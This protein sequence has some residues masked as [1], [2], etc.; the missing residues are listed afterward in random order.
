MS[1]LRSQH[2]LSQSRNSPHFTEPGSSL[3]LTQQPDICPA[4][5]TTLPHAK[6]F[7][8]VR[9][10][11]YGC[12]VSS[13]SVR[14]AV[15][16]ICLYQSSRIVPVISVYQSSR[17]V[18]V[19]CLYQS[20]RAVPVSCLYQSSRAVF[21]VLSLSLQQGNIRSTNFPI[22]SI[23]K[24]NSKNPLKPRFFSLRLLH[25]KLPPVQETSLNRVTLM[26]I[27]YFCNYSRGTQKVQTMTSSTPL[28]R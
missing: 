5:Q 24:C 22:Q 1:F 21:S 20:S 13:V 9:I 14:M 18:S 10:S 23:E 26:I 25:N 28:S 2:V 11:Q 6:P 3:P 27:N 19:S 15:P 4:L 8:C 7:H 17:A 16:A 12:A